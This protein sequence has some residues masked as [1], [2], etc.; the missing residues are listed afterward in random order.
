M[1]FNKPYLFKKTNT[2][3]IKHPSDK[4]LRI[5]PDDERHC[6]PNG[7][8]GKFAQW[9]ADPQD[10]G[11]CCRFKSTKSGN[12]LRIVKKGGAHVVDAAGGGGKWTVF[13]VNHLQD[14]KDG[15][16]KLESKE[17]PGVFLA[18]DGKCVRTG[19]GGKWCKMLI[20]KEIKVSDADGINDGVKDMN[21]NNAPINKPYMF[22][23][24]NTILIKH[25][26][27]KHLRIDPDDQRKCNHKGGIGKFAHWEADPQDGGEFCRFKSIKSGK[28][29]RIVKK[30]DD[31]LV[32]AAGGGGKWTVFK[33]RHGSDDRDG[34][35]K[36]ESKE[37]EGVFLAID[38][39]GVRTGNGGKWCQLFI[40][41]Q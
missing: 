5:D 36:L 32:D 3:V 39:S 17:M 4:H 41:R 37:L 26:A 31:H 18:I 12:Y 23:K 21:L 25:A 19:S 15:W 10:G 35:C 40:K 27:G 6:N 2:V 22:R 9:E 7:G 34:V 33:V 16:C 20:K 29:L 11:D 28:Y 24:T 38:D 8:I 14:D 13:K 30:G 1:P